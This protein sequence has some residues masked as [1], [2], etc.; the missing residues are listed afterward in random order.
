MKTHVHP[1]IVVLSFILAG[2]LGWSVRDHQPSLADRD[3]EAQR[4]LA[5][6]RADAWRERFA[7]APPKVTVDTVIVAREVQRRDSIAMMILKTREA[8]L[9]AK[10]QHDSLRYA[11]RGWMQA[12]AMAQS[13]QNALDEYKMVYAAAKY[14]K[15]VAD[16]AA[17]VIQ[18]LQDALERETKARQ[19]RVLV[20]GCPTRKEVAI[21][22]AGGGLILGLLLSR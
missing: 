11:L 19:C 22:A 15:D 3:R 14:W 6:S 1:V 10:D 9:F 12:E 2:A 16:S 4:E 21:V 7:N 17:P 13:L 8:L 5:E 20:F 18:G